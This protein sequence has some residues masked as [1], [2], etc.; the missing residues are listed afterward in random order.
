[1]SACLE[2]NL[3]AL[4][5][6]DAELARTLRDTPAAS[7]L[8]WTPAR[9]EQ[10]LGAVLTSE[11]SDGA[12]RKVT[13]AGRVRPRQQAERFAEG[14]DLD[15]HGAFVV[16]GMGAG[17][18]V[19]ALVN[20][21][22]GRGV[23]IIHE[24]DPALL[25]AV[26]ENIDHSAWLGE[27]KVFLFTGEV[28][29]S[30]LTRRL[31]P[32]SVMI[33]QGVQ[34]FTHPPTR[35]LASSRIV[36][37]MERFT[38]FVAYCRTNMATTL[39]HSAR[40]C[41]NLARNL[42]QYAAGE[43]MN[44]LHQQAKG[45]PAVVV[46]AGPGLARNAHL[47]AEPG[48]RDGG[49]GGVVI[50]AVQTA[51]RPL[52]DRGVRPHFV[53]ALD[54][55]EISRRFYEDLPALDD[56]T[57]VA[58]PKVH[59]SVLESFPGPI[60][61]LQNSFLDTLLGPE[62]REMDALPSGS[63]VAHL[64]FY[65]A[66]Y[67][68]CDPIIFIGQDL[69]FSDGLYYCPGTAI[70]DVWAPELGAFN[71]L[72]MM[73]WKRIAR[74]KAHLRKRTDQYGGAIYSDEQMLTYLAQF[75]RDFAQ[76]PQKIIDATEGGMPK[77]HTTVMPLTEA[78]QAC[79]QSQPPSL[80][81]T[82]VALDPERLTWTQQRLRDRVKQ[83]RELRRTSKK[84]LP[85]LRRMLKDQRNPKKMDNHFAALEKLKHQADQRKEAL[86][87][88]DALNQIGVFKRF[89]ADRR[90]DAGHDEESDPYQ[91]QR[92]Q[93]ER[94]MENLEGL[95]AGCDEALNIFDQALERVPNQARACAEAEDVPEPILAGAGV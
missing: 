83:V 50:I 47:L 87:L 94:D 78:I 90:I 65:L 38:Q 55:H 18:H 12:S 70:H 64:S 69:G 10:S 67:L 54:Y 46:S 75:E 72:E 41:H 76:A 80:P 95:I 89:G 74:H 53:T 52:L 23:V 4:S 13:L 27:D 9:E 40:T 28:R 82:E 42:G 85:L 61:L 71:T 88:I 92:K 91:T 84:T 3:Q 62:A 2:K 16:L 49:G 86:N 57:L 66:Q 33:L 60:R 59:P 15:A 36:E 14:A 7:G 20:R 31:E 58:E 79:E 30:D 34:T 93:L 29:P 48:V 37:F 63:T 6:T 81:R 32:R 22:A 73:E 5:R 21:L 45:R 26:L 1:M 44:E 51:L 56:V 17:Y 43:A 11:A 35:Q 77:S 39:A 24:P 19:E 25:R 68:G 8:T